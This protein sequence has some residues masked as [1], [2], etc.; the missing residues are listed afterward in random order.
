MPNPVAGGGQDAFGGARVFGLEPGGKG[1]SEQHD[2]PAIADGVGSVDGRT[3]RLRVP[4]RQTALRGK[5]QQTLAESGH[6]RQAVARMHQPAKTA[7]IGR[8]ARQVRNQPRLQVQP[9]AASGLMQDLDLHAR[10]VDA[11]RAFALAGL[12]GDAEIE[13]V[14]HFVGGERVLAELTG[15]RESET[16][17]AAAGD[18]LLV[19][20]D[21]VGRAHHAGLRLSASAIVVAHLGGAEEPA[22]IG[23][24]QPCVQRQRRIARLE[25]EQAAVVHPGRIDDLAGIER[26]FGIEGFFDLPERANQLRSEHA[27]VKL[28]AHQPVA[29]LA[30]MGTLVALDQL[31]R[32]LSDRSEGLDVLL[33]L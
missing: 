23:P 1:I 21:A 13:R 20:C 2:V 16:V 5:A 32:F 26:A 30:G 25:A 18:M 10:H 3:K 12:A 11:G 17:G 14:T 31:H 24:I 28:G 6:C 7:G 4:A 19:G 9:M 22:P 29:M 8:I 27:L 33:L 15:K